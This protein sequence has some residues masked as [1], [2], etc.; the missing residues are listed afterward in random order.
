MYII[1]LTVTLV[2]AAA[3]AVN[4]SLYLARYGKIS[5]ILL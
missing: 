2:T 3:D 1:N 4:K 5:E